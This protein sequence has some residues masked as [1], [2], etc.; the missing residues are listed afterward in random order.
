MTKSGAAVADLTH[1][2]DERE[3]ELVS[4]LC[5]HFFEV[6]GLAFVANGCTHSEPCVEKCLDDPCANEAVGSGDED[7]SGGDSWHGV[8]LERV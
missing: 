4:V 8:M 5:E 2:W 1:V 6:D 7:L 3:L